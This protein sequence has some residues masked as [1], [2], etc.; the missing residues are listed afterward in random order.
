M[1]SNYEFEIIVD[2]LNPAVGPFK[3]YANVQF[4]YDWRTGKKVEV[5]LDF[6]EVHGHSAEEA[7]TKMQVKVDGWLHEKGYEV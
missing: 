2:E 7:R 3:F 4:F 1:R 5:P 6:G